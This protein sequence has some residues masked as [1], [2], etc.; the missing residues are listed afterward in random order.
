MAQ[1][2]PTGTSYLQLGVDEIPEHDVEVPG[3]AQGDV[4]V[5]GDVEV[6]NDVEVNIA[7]F[8][9]SGSGRSSFVNAIRGYRIVFLFGVLLN[10]T[11]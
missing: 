3:D 4:D 5:H 6:Q 1:A 8:G 2:E 9:K 7:M 11:F 10:K